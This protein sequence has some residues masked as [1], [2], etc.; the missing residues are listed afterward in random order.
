MC[1]IEFQGSLP[2]LALAPGDSVRYTL[3]TKPRPLT[4]ALHVSSMSTLYGQCSYYRRIRAG[5]NH[6]ALRLG[7]SSFQ[8][9]KNQQ[10][11]SGD[12][13]YY[14]DSNSAACVFAT[15]HARTLGPVTRDTA[16]RLSNGGLA[17]PA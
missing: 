13:N 9:K 17:P 4:S 10:S 14:T 2:C 5:G 6:A 11:H 12:R 7:V 1:D 8:K 3:E 16:Q 15:Q